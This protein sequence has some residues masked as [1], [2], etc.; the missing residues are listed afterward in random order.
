MWLKL[1]DKKCC[2]TILSFS[3]CKISM[4]AMNEC[5]LGNLKLVP[6]KVTLDISRGPIEIQWGSGK[7]PR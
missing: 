2:F 1:H 3:F 5:C 7:Y 6:V 4:A